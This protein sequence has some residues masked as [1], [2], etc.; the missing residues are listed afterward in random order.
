MPR[1]RGGGKLKTMF[2]RLMVVLLVLAGVVSAPAQDVAEGSDVLVPTGPFGTMRRVHSETLILPDA[3]AV[4][5]AQQRRTVAMESRE[6]AA[7]QTEVLRQAEEAKKAA[8]AEAAAS[9][10]APEPETVLVEESLESFAPEPVAED[11][12]PAAVEETVDG[13]AAEDTL[14]ATE[15]AVEE[16]SVSPPEPETTAE[17]VQEPASEPEA[18]PAAESESAPA[19]DSGGTS[20]ASE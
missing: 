11:T 3:G 20:E 12:V 1:G 7:A 18:A 17:P 8:S 5:R 14:P 10:P 9:T 15:S 2:P 13:V 19:P 4:L 16:A 6:R